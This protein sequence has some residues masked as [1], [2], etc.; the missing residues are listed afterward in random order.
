[1]AAP[2]VEGLSALLVEPAEAERAHAVV[3]APEPAAQV[4]LG[5]GGVDLLR[6]GVG[7]GRGPL[8][9]LAHRRETSVGVVE[10]RL[11]L[12]HIG[13]GVQTFLLR[14]HARERAAEPRTWGG[15]RCGPLIVVSGEPDVTVRVG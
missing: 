2:D 12:G 14:V 13:M 8:G 3:K 15:L 11:L 9:S 6:R 1:V 4:V 5:D 7:D 10:V